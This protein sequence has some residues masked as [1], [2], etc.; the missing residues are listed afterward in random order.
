MLEL[1]RW[2]QAA[3]ARPREGLRLSSRLPSL[4]ALRFARL[5]ELFRPRRT[6]HRRGE[7]AAQSLRAHSPEP[8]PES[9]VSCEGPWS[10]SP[11]RAGGVRGCKA[12]PRLATRCCLLLP[13]SAAAA[14]ALPAR[15]QERDLLATSGS[16][17]RRGA[18][19]FQ[20]VPSLASATA[21][22]VSCSPL[23]GIS[24]AA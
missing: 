16:F 20:E 10:T 19:R 14:S 3:A 6:R 22:C 24:P 2:C 8:L 1:W 13:K 9:P 17:C 5:P 23:K 15:F 21:P 12:A 11:P 7:A 4:C 18:M